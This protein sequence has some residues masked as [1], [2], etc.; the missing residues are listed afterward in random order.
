MNETFLEAHGD[1]GETAFKKESLAIGS[2]SQA[3]K[4]AVSRRNQSRQ[5]DKNSVTK[6]PAARAKHDHLITLFKCG[7]HTELQKQLRRLIKQ[8]PDSGFA[9]KLLG[10]SLQLQGK[11]AIDALRTAV[12]L[13]PSDAEAHCNL[14]VAFKQAGDPA[15]AIASYRRAL[16]INGQYAQAHCY[17]ANAQ[18]ELGLFEEALASC[19]H[20]LA[21]A[22]ECWEAHVTMGTTLNAVG[23]FEPSLGSMRRAVALLLQ[24]YRN[25]DVPP[26]AESLDC[27]QSKTPMRVTDAKEVL[28]VLRTRLD[29]VSIPWCLFAGTLL[30]VIRDGD[31][32]PYDK[33]MDIALA[34]DVDRKQLIQ[35]LT[36]DGEFRL[37]SRLNRGL[38]N[39]HIYD[40]CFMHAR[41]HVTVD[42]F[43]LHP[44]GQDHFLVGTDH[45][46]QPVLCR[47][48]RFDIGLRDWRDEL[49][50]VPIQHER[51]F[52]D[53]YGADWQ[54]PDPY[55]DTT[56][57]NPSRIAEAIPF[58][59]CYGY[60][61]LFAHLRNCKWQAAKAYCKQL[62]NRIVDPLLDE[63]E[64]WVE[65]RIAF[66]VPPC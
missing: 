37:A 66:P 39:S 3:V 31:L 57:S 61:R 48:S 64:Q 13:L 42:L 16:D 60:A 7:A 28:D 51:Y 62:R 5:L 4:A 14:G 52:C 59:L 29:A 27:S 9:W 1:E 25:L 24:M 21:I 17:L 2:L 41:H 45:P 20:S 63:V 53:V 46:G 22:P 33:D 18:R 32:L 23:Q 43:F 10:A 35:L 30:G 6:R 12:R 55:Y 36:A 15:S 65:Q 40:M 8:T 50:P 11:Y 38:Q 19:R 49:W 34:C 47:I 54:Q 26:R 58:V 44:D 56:I